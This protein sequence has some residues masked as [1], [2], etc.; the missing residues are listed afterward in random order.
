MY[1]RA[2]DGVFGIVI[3]KVSYIPI[4]QN[5]TIPYIT[6]SILIQITA[7]PFIHYLKRDRQVA[8]PI[9]FEPKFL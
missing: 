8:R 9:Y 3:I 6:P 1:T 4:I 2:F 5:D 7:R